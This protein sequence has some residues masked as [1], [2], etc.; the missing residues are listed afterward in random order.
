MNAKCLAVLI[1]RMNTKCLA[2]FLLSP[3]KMSQGRHYYCLIQIQETLKLYKSLNDE[4][5]VKENK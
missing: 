4:H 2:I 5:I 3:L 1:S